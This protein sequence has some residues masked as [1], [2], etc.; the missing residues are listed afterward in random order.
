MP[1]VRKKT[2]THQRDKLRF[3]KN[4]GYRGITDYGEREYICDVV[5][6]PFGLT[7]I[8]GI[9]KVIQTGLVS[10]PLDIRES[11]FVVKEAYLHDSGHY[12]NA[13]SD[14]NSNTVMFTADG[15]HY[16]IRPRSFA[17]MMNAGVRDLYNDGKNGKSFDECWEEVSDYR[18]LM[19]DL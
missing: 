5:N 8:D 2:I 13:I 6:M 10:E 1:R 14:L 3:C 18:K 16:I 9:P 4:L 11:G 19:R 7:K 12:I 15:S 17:T